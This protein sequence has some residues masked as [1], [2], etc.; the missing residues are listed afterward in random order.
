MGRRAI[1]ERVAR[2]PTTHQITRSLLGADVG[3]QASTSK[4]TIDDANSSNV[5]WVETPHAPVFGKAIVKELPK[6][7]RIRP[8][9]LYRFR[10]AMAMNEPPRLLEPQAGARARYEEH[11]H[12]ILASD[13]LYLTYDH[14]LVRQP[15]PEPQRQPRDPSSPYTIGLGDYREG[16]LKPK[17][18][19]VTADESVELEAIH[20][21]FVH[22]DAYNNKT[23][24]LPV[25]GALRTIAGVQPREDG[26][27]D[28]NIG[29]QL[30]KTRPKDRKRGMRLGVPVGCNVRLA[31]DRMHAFLETLVEVVL[32]RWR[33]FRGISLPH[34]WTDEDDIHGSVTYTLPAEAVPLFPQ[35][36]VN[37][38]RYPVFEDLQIAFV[39]NARGEG[40]KSRAYSMLSG[41]RLPVRCLVVPLVRASQS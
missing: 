11:T 21:A 3:P 4:V 8:G 35:L 13:L 12:R 30:L 23:K 27:P 28:R 5:Q 39:T 37:A 14:R 17:A 22:S 7:D 33:N 32:P 40:A 24:L 36:E 26:E 10:P 9:H 15:A 19:A 41:Y 34:T 20:L 16:A 18:R 25:V 31:G 2:H 29:V 6:P 38:D 1:F